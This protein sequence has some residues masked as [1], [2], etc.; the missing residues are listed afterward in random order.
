MSDIVLEP[1]STR[2]EVGQ[3]TKDR[4]RS[5]S[6]TSIAGSHMRRYFAA[7]APPKPPPITT[8]RAFGP[9]LPVPVLAQPAAE[10]AAAAP[11][12]FRNSRRF[13]CAIRVSY[14][15]AAK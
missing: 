12:S 3:E 5:T 14:F 2:L 9:A 7:V 11:V 10:S 15:F 6:V 8:T 4:L 1:P 13:R